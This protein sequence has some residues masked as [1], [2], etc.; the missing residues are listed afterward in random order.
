MLFYE[1]PVLPENT[2]DIEYS[3]QRERHRIDE[4]SI[5]KVI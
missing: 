5:K 4:N 3:L 2:D 1:I